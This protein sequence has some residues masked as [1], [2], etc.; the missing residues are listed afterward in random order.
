MRIEP[1]GQP[2]PSDFQC[3]CRND[4]LA[5]QAPLFS[6]AGFGILGG[7]SFSSDMKLARERLPLAVQFP[8]ALVPRPPALY[9]AQPRLTIGET[10]SFRYNRGIR[11]RR[12]F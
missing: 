9:H 10:P 11:M 6:Q 4:C 7:R 5:R 1:W 12:I 2:Y 8:R 3:I